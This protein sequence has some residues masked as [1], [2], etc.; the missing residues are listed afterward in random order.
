M[1]KLNPNG[2]NLYKNGEFWL[3]IQTGDN[4]LEARKSIRSY[5]EINNFDFK[6]FTYQRFEN[7][8]N[9]G[10]EVKTIFAKPFTKEEL[11]GKFVIGFDTICEGNQCG[12]DEN[13]NPCPTLYDSYNEAFKEIFADAVCGVEGNEDC[14]KDNEELD[15]DVVIKEMEELIK[16]DDVEKMK[17]YFDKHPEANY[18]DEFVEKAEDFIVGRKALFTD[19]GV[20]VEGTKLEDL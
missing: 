10:F 15:R 9:E 3:V 8:S 2:F 1:K 4:E 13:D 18:Y 5:I 19:N 16:E 11:K 17:V 7:H 12:K 20:M 6:D 14:F